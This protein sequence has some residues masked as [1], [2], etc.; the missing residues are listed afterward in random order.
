[1][2]DDVCVVTSLCCKKDLTQGNHLAIS[3]ILDLI[4]AYKPF[5]LLLMSESF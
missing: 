5:F 4:G 3:T 2:Y 1:M